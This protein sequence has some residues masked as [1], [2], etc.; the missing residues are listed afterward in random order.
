MRA[1]GFESKKE[2]IRK[3]ISKIY[4]EST[5]KINFSD[6]LTMIVQKM[7]EKD[8]KEEILKALKFFSNDE[9]WKMS[10]KILKN[11]QGVKGT[12]RK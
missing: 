6:F 3:M 2:E 4:K 5:W 9:T 12:R 11:D 10:F 1:L 7:F 8:T